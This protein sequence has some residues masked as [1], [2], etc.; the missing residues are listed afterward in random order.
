MNTD[1]IGHVV[2]ELDKDNNRF[3]AG[4]KARK[5]NLQ[6]LGVFE[7]N[8]PGTNLS[9]V[10]FGLYKVQD[11][12]AEIGRFEDPTQQ[13]MFFDRSELSDAVIV[14]ANEPSNVVPGK[15]DTDQDIFDFY[16]EIVTAVCKPGDDHKNYGE[17]SFADV[18]NILTLYERINGLG[19]YVA[20]AK[21]EQTSKTLHGT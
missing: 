4:L 5:E 6:N 8:V 10:K 2:P 1:L 19:R 7:E 20:Q 15:I 12:H 11:Y 9:I 17:T 14:W 21:L 16:V 3:Y 13:P 18:R